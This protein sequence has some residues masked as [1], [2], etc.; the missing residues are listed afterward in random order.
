MFSRYRIYHFKDFTCV[1]PL[2]YY[3]LRFHVCSPGIDRWRENTSK[4][5]RTLFSISWIFL[6]NVFG[7]FSRLAVPQSREPQC[8]FPCP[9]W[10]SRPPPASECEGVPSD[11]WR[12]SLA[13]FLLSG[14]S[15]IREKYLK[16]VLRIVLDYRC[17]HTV[18]RKNQTCVVPVSNV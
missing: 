6:Q 9:N 15:K 8:L 14:L 17:I 2:S 12:K 18:L 16:K 3:H 13:L 1:L 11:D 5:A 10:D 4:I 7:R